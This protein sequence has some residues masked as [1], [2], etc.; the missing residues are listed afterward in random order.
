M[1]PET[2]ALVGGVL[3]LLIAATAVVFVLKRRAD[4]G[5]DPALLDTFWVRVRAWWVL[6]AALAGAFFIGRW[7][8]IALF[9]AI[10]LWALREFITVTPTRPGD[11]RALFWVFFLLTPLQFCLVGLKRY[12]WYSTLIPV[13]AFLFVLARVAMAGDAKRFLERTAKIQAGLLICVYCLS[14]APALLTLDL[15]HQDATSAPQNSPGNSS[16][17][18]ADQQGADGDSKAPVDQTGRQPS[19]ASK[20]TAEAEGGQP[21]A[22]AVRRK[23]GGTVRLLFFFVLMVQLS[24]A[25]QYVWSRLPSRHVIVPAISQT[26]TWEGFL[27]GT[28]SVTLVGTA[29]CF[30]TPFV[31]WWQAACTSLAIGVMAF[32]G[33]L[34]MSAIKRDR[35]VKDFGTLVE[36]HGGVLD[37]IDSICFAAPI[38]FHLARM[39]LHG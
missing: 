20:E 7:A 13:Y 26:R 11:H 5:L 19:D 27:G 17:E 2:L 39:F 6:F 28:A 8:T 15:P 10:S 29:L 16:S 14:F 9:W 36:G 33:K 25:L 12:D 31:H 4:S 18:P 37:R 23:A 21:V 22:R 3:V 32:A 24:D 34:T 1:D 30:T 38:F 35:G